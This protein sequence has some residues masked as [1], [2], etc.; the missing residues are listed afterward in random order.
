[1]Y[2]EQVSD[3]ELFRL[4]GNNDESEAELQQF[5]YSERGRTIAALVG[6]IRHGDF[7]QILIARGILLPSSERAYRLQLQAQFGQ[8]CLFSEAEKRPDSQG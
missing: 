5:R 6:R 7:I 1:M 8:K 2:L 3:S 4:Y